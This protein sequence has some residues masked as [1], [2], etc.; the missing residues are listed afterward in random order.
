MKRVLYIIFIVTG[1]LY[2]AACVPKNSISKT[3]AVTPTTGAV[4][5]STPGPTPGEIPAETPLPTP[6]PEPTVFVEPTPEPTPLL[7]ATPEPTPGEIPAETPSP[8]PT[9]QP[10]ELPVPTATPKPTGVP[11]ATATPKPTKVPRVT[12]TSTPQPTELP[13]PTTEPEEIP[14]T[15]T[16]TPAVNP[17]LLVHQ[18]WQKAVDISGTYAIIFSDVFQESYVT[19]GDR[20]L[21]TIYLSP[22][23]DAITFDVIY[24][25]KRTMEEAEEEILLA[26]GIILERQEEN[27]SFSYL[28]IVGD[29]I[30]CGRVQEEQ[31]SRELLGTSFGEN[32][33]ITGTMQAVF[34]YPKEREELYSTE[35]YQ[36]FIIPV[37]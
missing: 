6:T 10:T 4:A 27:R 29:D 17:E 31:F 7:T 35:Q 14:V 25:M 20:E 1:A 22:A 5:Q 26:G 24:T 9:P 11:K 23:D 34:S 3:P 2:F 21:R 13:V 32:P 15:I 19:R 8:T 12:P 30:A 33:V 37:S 36:F 18:G 28:L 16:P